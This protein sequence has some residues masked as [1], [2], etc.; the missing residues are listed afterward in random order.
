MHEH[1]VTIDWTWTLNLNDTNLQ[2]SRIRIVR[3]LNK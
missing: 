2:Q 3:R 1:V